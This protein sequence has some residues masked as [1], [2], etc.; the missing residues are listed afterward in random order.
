METDNKRPNAALINR[1][2]YESACKVL[3]PDELGRLLVCVVEYVLDGI[4][5]EGL[6]GNASVVFT[7]VRQL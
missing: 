2:W 4:E 6:R 7:M 3:N 5:P 1:E